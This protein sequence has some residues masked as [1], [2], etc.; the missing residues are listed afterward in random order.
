[1]A[2]INMLKDVEGRH[3]GQP[4]TTPFAVSALP[5]GMCVASSPHAETPLALRKK[6][7]SD[8]A[9]YQASEN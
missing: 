8:N 2:V 9:T 6:L 1:M 3:Q 7:S 4:V 5:R